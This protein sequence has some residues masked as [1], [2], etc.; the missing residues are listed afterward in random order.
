MAVKIIELL[1]KR[2]AD[3]SR[4]FECAVA[5]YD[6]STSWEDSA[7][8]VEHLL[9]VFETLTS[10]QIDKLLK[11]YDRTNDNKFSFRGRRLLMP[12]LKK[13]TGK[14]YS[15][16]HTGDLAPDLDTNEG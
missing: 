8:K 2:L 6:A 11:A 4:L 3:K 7:W 1:Y 12:L 13:W 9:S 5:A 10:D 16:T 14:N 15:L